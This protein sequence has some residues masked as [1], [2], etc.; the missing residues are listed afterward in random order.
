MSQFSSSA[1]AHTLGIKYATDELGRVGMTLCAVKIKKKNLKKERKRE[2]TDVIRVRRTYE[3][4]D[5]FVSKLLKII[6]SNEREK[7]P[8]DGGRRT[9]THTHTISRA[10]SDVKMSVRKIYFRCINTDCV[11]KTKTAR[12]YEFFFFPRQ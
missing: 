6:L 7:K 12:K 4:F 2:R 10:N 11:N 8:T 1:Y 5:I 9:H 3:W